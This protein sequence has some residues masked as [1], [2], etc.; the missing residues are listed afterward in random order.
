VSLTPDELIIWQSG[1]WRLTSTVACTW[2]VMAL[3]G[4]GS[5]L[6]TRRLSSGAEISRWQNLL[7]VIVQFIRDQIRQIAG[8][9]ADRYVPFIGTLFIFIAVANILGVLPII[10]FPANEPGVHH[11]FSYRPPTGSLST[12]AALAVC[13]FFAVPIYGIARRGLLGY[14]KQ[15]V[16]PAILMLPFNIIGE[17][18]RTLALAVRLFGNVMSGSLIVGVLLGLVPIFFPTIMHV[19]GLV[20]GLIQA[21]IFAILA[22]VYI[23]SATRV[24]RRRPSDAQAEAEGDA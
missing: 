7:E 3:L 12:T 2:F 14:L 22:M 20:T 17:L 6:I 15:Y 11:L 9:R 24:Q 16:Q 13:V 4:V 1:I 10:Q 5:W 23:A 19:L 18:S 21:Y 8:E